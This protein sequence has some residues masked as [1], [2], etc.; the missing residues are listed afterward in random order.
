M[1]GSFALEAALLAHGF[2]PA[3]PEIFEPENTPS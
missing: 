2:T 1:M 3:A